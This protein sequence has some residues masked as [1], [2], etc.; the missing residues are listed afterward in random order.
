MLYKSFM[1]GDMPENAHETAITKNKPIFL[2]V[3]GKNS[4]TWSKQMLNSTVTINLD[5]LTI[6]VLARG[7]NGLTIGP[8]K[9][10]GHV[11]AAAKIKLF[12]RLKR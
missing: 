2:S 8:I 12:L 3:V 5:K 11:R 7:E 6:S 9:I 1:K 4:A 10:D